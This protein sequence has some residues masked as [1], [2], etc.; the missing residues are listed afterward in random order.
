MIVAFNE[1]TGIGTMSD[2]ATVQ[3]EMAGLDLLMVVVFH[4][5]DVVVHLH[6]PMETGS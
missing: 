1:W 4:G 6:N 5:E 2:E 3:Y